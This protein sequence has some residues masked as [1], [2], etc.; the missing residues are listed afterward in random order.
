MCQVAL[1]RGVRIAQLF[2]YPEDLGDWRKKADMITH[3]ILTEAW[4]PQIRA[5]TEHL[6]GGGLDASLLSLPLRRV[7]PA[8][9]PRMIATIEAIRR[10]LDA[11]N[12]LLYRYRIDESPDGLSEK[13]GAFLLCSFWLVDNLTA[14][15]RI[16]EAMDLYESLCGRASSLGL[17]SEQIDPVSGTFLGNFPQALSHIG[18]IS[19]GFNLS[20]ALADLTPLSTRP[21]FAETAIH[22]CG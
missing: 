6:G 7:I 19:S 3:S 10:H 17:F 20:R 18:V 13:Q 16:D 11:G 22:R 14:L 5:I 21:G 4:D 12:G 1:D 2:G 8:D 9:H 15:G